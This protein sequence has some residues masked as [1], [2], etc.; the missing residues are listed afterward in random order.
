MDQ[1]PQPKIL[2]HH[3]LDRSRSNLH[4]GAPAGVTLV[5]RDATLVVSSIDTA[6]SSDQVVLLTLATGKTAV[7]TRGVGVNKNS[8]GGLHRA[9]NA[10]ILAWADVSRSGKIYRVEP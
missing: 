1:P 5:G 10:P 3:L 9:A 7:A 4:L 2:G 6:T 8:S